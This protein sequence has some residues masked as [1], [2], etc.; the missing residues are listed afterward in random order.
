MTPTE[1]AQMTGQG[2][3]LLFCPGLAPYPATAPAARPELPLHSPIPLDPGP[4]PVLDPVL[5]QSAWALVGAST[6]FH[7]CGCLQNM[8]D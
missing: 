2:K 8:I 1:A 7:Q 5:V 3:S 6:T 4:N